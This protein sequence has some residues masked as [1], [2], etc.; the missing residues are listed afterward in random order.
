MARET[1]CGI[2]K[3]ERTISAFTPLRAKR[4]KKKKGRQAWENRKGSTFFR[5]PEVRGRFCCRL[6]W[7][8]DPRR[9]LQERGP[10][11][12]SEGRT[13]KAAN[14]PEFAP[15]QIEQAAQSAA[16]DETESQQP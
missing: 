12:C 3:K 2:E 10:S 14:G 11:E 9:K 1:R 15:I 7:H 6:P 16:C 13:E 8:D 4:F 5:L